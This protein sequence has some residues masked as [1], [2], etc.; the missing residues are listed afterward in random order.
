MENVSKKGKYDSNHNPGAKSLPDR[1]F[2]CLSNPV[3]L[4][5]ILLLSK[6]KLNVN[7][8]SSTFN[9]S[10]PK[11]SAQ[12]SILQNYG[13]VHGWQV[14]REKY[15][16]II[17]E[18][19]ESLT[20]WLDN[21]ATSVTVDNLPEFDSHKQ[22][23]KGRRCY[24]HMAG[25]SG[26]MLLKLLLSRKWISIKNDKPEYELTDSGEII[27]TRLEEVAQNVSS[28]DKEF[29]RNYTNQAGRGGTKC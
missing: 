28:K 25:Q 11:I 1:L 16:K 6:G 5:I 18:S 21:I 13:I 24:D 8:L 17:P 26:V 23:Q 12:L 9:V 29:R 22:F 10:Q 2:Y 3:R 4:R 27:L 19:I 14:G 20:S 7:Q 15:Y